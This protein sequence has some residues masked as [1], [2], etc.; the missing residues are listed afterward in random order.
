LLAKT[1]KFL[2]NFELK[3]LQNYER[4][5]DERD[6]V[7]VEYSRRMQQGTNDASSMEERSKVLLRTFLSENPD[8]K[9]KDA[10]RQFTEEEKWAIW[11]LG[12]KTCAKCGIAAK[13]EDFDADHVVRYAEGG[14]TV[15]SN[16]R[17]YCIKCNRS[18][19]RPLR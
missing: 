17:V 18:G 11:M 14:S 10:S 4:P 6:P 19:N 2:I 1:K 3:R 7:L 15:L 13:W 9:I 5:E 12:G 8:V 16:G